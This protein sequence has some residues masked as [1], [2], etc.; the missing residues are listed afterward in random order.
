M[1]W[2]ATCIDEYGYFK[3]CIPMDGRVCT[4]GCF[5]ASAR[6]GRPRSIH[7]CVP[8]ATA[9][10][11]ERSNSR[12]A[13]RA[14]TCYL[15]RVLPCSGGR[16]RQIAD[17]DLDIVA[18]R[19]TD[20]YLGADCQAA[21]NAAATLAGSIKS[22]GSWADVNYT[23]KGRTKWGPSAHW[24]HIATLAEGWACAACPAASKPSLLGAAG[25]AMGFWNQSG[26]V[27]PNW[28]WNA[29]GVPMTAAKA[30]VL[31]RSG[32]T[33]A[34]LSDADT[35]LSG[36]DIWPHESGQNR[37]WT[38]SIVMNRAVVHANATEAAYTF[39]QLF[40]AVAVVS[41]CRRCRRSCS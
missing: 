12:G 37:I 10:F 3:V 22:D 27:C 29:I 4:V 35:V 25:A 18:T 14:S 19:L 39:E 11:L 2:T 30:A 20:S 8:R 26:L 21:C 23:D 17:G 24:T 15:R 13:L 9:C 7:W 32:L 38:L 31:L 33:A 6:R 28:W 5:W 36:A 41:L 40:A 1:L 16:G 34:M